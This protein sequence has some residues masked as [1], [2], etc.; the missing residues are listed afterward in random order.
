MKHNWIE[1]IWIKVVLDL[2]T[3]RRAIDLWGKEYPL[4]ININIFYEYI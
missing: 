3:N 2:K 4:N 1:W